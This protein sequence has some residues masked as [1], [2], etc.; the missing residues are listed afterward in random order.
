MPHYPRTWLRLKSGR[1][2]VTVLEYGLI[3]DVIVAAIA[4]EL[5]ILASH[6]SS[7]FEN[8]GTGF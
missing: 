5:T 4:V 8:I 1:S 2:A 3:A 6:L 7:Q